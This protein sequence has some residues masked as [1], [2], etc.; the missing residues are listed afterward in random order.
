MATTERC[1]C[2]NFVKSIGVRCSSTEF[3]VLLSSATPPSSS[4]QD[5]AEQT[6]VINSTQDGLRAVKTGGD[7]SVLRAPWC[8]AEMTGSRQ[9]A[10]T[11]ARRENEVKTTFAKNPHAW[12]IFLAARLSGRCWSLRR[13]SRSRRLMRLRT[14]YTAAGCAAI[15][16]RR[17][18]LAHSVLRGRAIRS[19]RGVPVSTGLCSAL[20]LARLSKRARACKHQSA[21]QYELLH[22]SSPL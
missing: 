20:S 16:A 8:Q 17:I 22:G 7:R 14:A 21:D 15:D 1:D 18:T 12:L 19:C 10:I 2:E 3:Y 11:S 9:K 4:S 5:R 13:G 6:F